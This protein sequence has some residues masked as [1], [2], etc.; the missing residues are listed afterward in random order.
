MICNTYSI[1][2]LIHPPIDF[3][4]SINEN[5][6]QTINLNGE[7]EFIQLLDQRNPSSQNIDAKLGIDY[8]LYIDKDRTRVM[9]NSRKFKILNIAPSS[10]I[11][12]NW[13]ILE[14]KEVFEDEA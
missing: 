12:K 4:G 9:Y 2:L 5:A 3:R 13:Q 7:M 1:Q 10:F 14:L 11:Y 6:I 8:S